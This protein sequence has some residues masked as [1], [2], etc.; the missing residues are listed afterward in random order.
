MEAASSCETSAHLYQR[1]LC[2]ISEDWNLYHQLCKNLQTLTNV[3]WPVLNSVLWAH[4]WHLQGSVPQFHSGGSR[5][6][7]EREIDNLY[8]RVISVYWIIKSQLLWCPSISSFLYSSLFHSAVLVFF[9]F[10]PSLLVF[11]P[12]F[13]HHLF[14]RPFFLMTC[15][16]VLPLHLQLCFTLHSFSPLLFFLSLTLSYF[17]SDN[18]TSSERCLYLYVPCFHLSVTV[19]CGRQYASKSTQ[20]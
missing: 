3:T 19:T 12:F 11:D 13:R 6:D 10:S 5:F 20:A 1:T 17:A 14:L 4:L 2:H 16:L 15:S 7:S 9:H 18:I 8:S